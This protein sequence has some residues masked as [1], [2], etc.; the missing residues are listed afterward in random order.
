M[1]EKIVQLNEEVIKGQ[2]K[3]LVRGSLQ[4]YNTSWTEGGEKEEG[5]AQIGYGR[6]VR[7]QRPKGSANP[8][9]QL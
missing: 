9:W 2:L 8:S 6:F 1:C 5:F 7:K 3:E 4:D